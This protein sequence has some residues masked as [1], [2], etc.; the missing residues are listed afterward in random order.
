MIY[1]HCEG[2]KTGRQRSQ[3]KSFGWDDLPS[4]LGPT[5]RFAGIDLAT[6]RGSAAPPRVGLF[7]GLDETVE[8]HGY[9]VR[10]QTASERYQPEAV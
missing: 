1:K 8:G 5:S 4:K 3:V 2:I 9:E 10:G 7:L 6:P